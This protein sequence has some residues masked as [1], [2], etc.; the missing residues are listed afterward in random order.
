MRERLRE[1]VPVS[2]REYAEVRMPKW[3]R[4]EVQEENVK[5]NHARK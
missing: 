4:S 5:S 1:P 3:S 2:F